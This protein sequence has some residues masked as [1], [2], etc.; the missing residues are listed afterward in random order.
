MSESSNTVYN[1]QPAVK[2]VG[3]PR[4][5]VKAE[6]EEKAIARAERAVEEGE[7]GVHERAFQRMQEGELNSGPRGQLA[8]DSI[9]YDYGPEEDLRDRDQNE[10]FVA[11]DDELQ[12]Q[13]AR[14][15]E[16]TGKFTV[17][18]YDTEKSQRIRMVVFGTGPET[19]IREFFREFCEE[20]YAPA[21]TFDFDQSIGRLEEAMDV[22]IVSCH[23]GISTERIQEA[24][25]YA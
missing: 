1:I 20:N 3:R 8:G 2:F 19:A 22:M 12:R 4:I 25:S 13:K 17:I 9:A 11:A 16:K 24:V 23:E 21:V 14:E 18:G 6:T 7:Q 15:R 5:L 10:V